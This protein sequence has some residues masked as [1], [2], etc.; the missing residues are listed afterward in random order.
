MPVK[1]NVLQVKHGDAF[2]IECQQG[3][4][5]GIVVVDG[6]PQSTS[7][8]F[9]KALDKY[10]TIDLLVL[11]HYDED[12]IGGILSYFRTCKSEDRPL[13]IKQIWANC[14]LSIDFDYDKNLS[15][16]QAKKLSDILNEYVEKKTLVWRTDICEGVKVDFGFAQ[17]EVV[18]PTKDVMVESVAKIP[19]EEQ[20][21]DLNLA[22]HSRQINDLNTPLEELAQI[23]KKASDLNDPGQLTNASSIAFILECDGTRVLMLGDSYPQTIVEYFKKKCTNRVFPIKIDY[24]KV[25]HHG[26]RNNTNNDLLGMIDCQNF[27]FSTNGGKGNT[28][29][30]DRE[31]IANIVCQPMR[32]NDKKI[33]LFF[34]YNKTI[35]ETNGHKFIN[36]DEPQRYNFEVHDNTTCYEIN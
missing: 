28:S 17:I 25:S 7:N 33:Y 20:N 36:D 30:P 29:H 32:D 23:E 10:P 6:G 21:E 11:T 2:I 4:N 18:S 3:D 16:K 9:R 5:K 1:I 14:A 34:N 26:S 13:K 12:H 24:T 31:T 8:V 27:I 22:A 15:V 19:K 35:I